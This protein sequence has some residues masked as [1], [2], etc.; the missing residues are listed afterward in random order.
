VLGIDDGW[1]LLAYSLCVFSSALCVLYGVVNWNKGDEPVS[2]EDVEW[3]KEEQ[4]EE[5][6]L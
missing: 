3:A 2:D 6:A 4:E 1:V 5:E